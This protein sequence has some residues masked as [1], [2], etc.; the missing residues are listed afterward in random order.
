MKFSANEDNMNSFEVLPEGDYEFEV[1]EAI[2]QESKRGG[3]QWKVT[4]RM[5]PTDGKPSRKVWEY[6]PETEKMKWKFASFLKCVGLIPA[7]SS[8]EF[9]TAL[10]KD[11][12]GEIGKCHLGIQ[13]AEGPYP[14][15]NTVKAFLRPEK[16]AA[17]EAPKAPV[18]TSDDLP[19]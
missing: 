10:M 9:D 13:P 7:D 3:Y 12:V 19:F 1:E 5:D 17:K 8:E 15:K 4:L 16:E 2:I 6:F 11:A 18:I 14:E